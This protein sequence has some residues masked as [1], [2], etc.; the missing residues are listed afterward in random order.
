M[1]TSAKELKQYYSSKEFEEKYTYDG[2]L[3]AFLD[4]KGAHFLLWSPM[5]DEVRLRFFDD[6]DK[7]PVTM[8]VS[9]EPLEKGV[10][11][12]RG[13]KSLE[14][15]YYDYVVEVEGEVFISPDPYAK[16]AGVN[17][18]RSQLLDLKT[19]NPEGWE[20]DVAPE[21]ESEDVIYE[22]NIHDFSWDEAA[23]YPRELRGTY[24]ALGREK[25][26]ETKPL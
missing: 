6:G 23:G 7:S 22:L 11:C 24:G 3:G 20:A 19:T 8:E 15:H 17:G 12:Y 2:K 14:G 5:A 18:R 16:A 13:D 10:W 1:K 21:K 26:E 4:E 9:M 25:Y